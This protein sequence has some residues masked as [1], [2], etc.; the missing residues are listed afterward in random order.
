MAR[1]SSVDRALRRDIR[2][3]GSL[4]GEV[5]IAQEGRE[6]FELEEQVR[7]LAIGRRRG[8]KAQR[9]ERT[10]ALEQLLRSLPLE[11]AEPVVRAFSTY[12]QLANLAE[13]NHRMRRTRE[14]AREPDAKAQRGSLLEIFQRAK[15]AGATA[16]PGRARGCAR[17]K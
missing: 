7:T 6:L 16:D 5:L 8:P 12:F 14:H 3:L 17:C 1:K 2:Q 9:K 4:L 10:K 11:Q 15:A 13:Q